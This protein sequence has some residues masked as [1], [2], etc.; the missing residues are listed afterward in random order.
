MAKT[1]TQQKTKSIEESLWQSCDKL[2]GS[3]E[4]SEYKHV[5]L[6]LIFLKFTSDKF[7]KRKQEL[8]DEGQEKYVEMKEFYNM[9]NVFFLNEKSRWS[10]II[11]N[12]KQDDIAIKIDTA[13]HDIEKNNPSLRGALPDN[14]FSR[15][16]LDKSKLAALLDNIN[17]IDTLK[18]ADQDIVGRVYEYF[19]SKFALKEGK[20]KG[21]F[22][23]PKSIVNLIAEMIEP[24]RGIIYDPACGS[25]GM[26]VQS[27]KFI[28]NHHGNKKEVSIYG[29][30][31][32][33]TT[34]KLAKMNLAI[35][36]IN[37]NL[38]DKAADT[39]GNDQHKDLKADF[40]MANPP[41]NQKAWRG[42]DELNDDPRWQG[43]DIPPVSNAN[44][45]WILNIVAKLS[46]DGVAGFILANGALSGGG[47]EYK[48][49]KKL[50]ENDLVEAIVI[51]P[52]NM[53]YTTNISVT[54]WILNKNKKDRSLKLPDKTR[55]FKNRESETLFMDL[56]QIGVPLEKKF[57]QFSPEQI[58]HVSK[59]YHNWQEEH[60]EYKDVP[61]FCYAASKAEIT[62]KDYSLVPSKYI[63]FI[64]RDENI[65]FDDKM[66]VLQTEIADLLQQEAASKKELEKVFKSLGY[67]L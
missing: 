63:E 28:E 50:I 1:N 64:N 30:E 2:R 38:G 48:I 18:D 32:T 45:A 20:G 27:I 9:K 24:Y 22:Y 4:P 36:G 7:E 46:E 43:Y 3:I 5:V 55:Q 16:G 19:L 8:I 62:K 61:E 25:G 26:F 13:L 57:I 11:K 58:E 12:A 21:E 52:Q 59:T 51:L 14:Y 66:K 15:L 39:F 42:K 6:G 41:F 33:N 67:E 37:A 23:T 49:R 44:Y 34:Y 40:I 54:L 53:F 35:R 56:R 10:Y 47:E 29:Q 65:D 60:A 17:D 31:Y